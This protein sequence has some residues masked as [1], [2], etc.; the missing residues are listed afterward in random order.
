MKEMKLKDSRCKLRVFYNAKPKAKFIP[1]EC[2][3]NMVMALEEA[4][5]IE[6]KK[7]KTNQI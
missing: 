1:A 7:K 6:L 2:L 4:L 5:I 3:H